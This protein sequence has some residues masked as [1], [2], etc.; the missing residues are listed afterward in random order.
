MPV[1]Q[2]SIMA[3]RHQVLIIQKHDPVQVTGVRTQTYQNI[4]IVRIHQQQLTAPTTECQHLGGWTEAYDTA[5]GMGVEHDVCRPA[6]WIG[7]TA[8]N[9][10][11]KQCQETEPENRLAIQ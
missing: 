8:G 5:A 3:C 7:H 9:E 1:T 11:E 10:R 4:S 2:C 6:R